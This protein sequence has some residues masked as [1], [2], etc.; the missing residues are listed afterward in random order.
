MSFLS[1]SFWQIPCG[2]KN[3]LALSNSS[4]GN[5]S[6]SLLLSF[7]SLSPSQSPLGI[8]CFAQCVTAANSVLS[9]SNSALY[10]PWNR[11]VM[12]DLCAPSSVGRYLQTQV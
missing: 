11:A 5:R 2:S 12:S 7:A 3:F 8:S 1:S 4:S 10:E 9:S 6:P